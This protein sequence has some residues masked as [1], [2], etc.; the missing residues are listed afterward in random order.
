MLPPRTETFHW[1]GAKGASGCLGCAFVVC[2]VASKL[3]C[4]LPRGLWTLTAHSVVL[5][6]TFKPQT[7]PAHPHSLQDFADTLVWLPGHSGLQ[8]KPAKILHALPQK[9]LLGHSRPHSLHR[10]QPAGRGGGGSIYTWTKASSQRGY[11]QRKVSCTQET[12]PWGPR[13]CQSIGRAQ[14]G[15]GGRAGSWKQLSQNCQATQHPVVS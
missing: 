6:C 12:V 13:F 2:S 9:T 15:G 14:P 1:A 3:V 4:G 5:N 10:A 7:P 11:K 8:C